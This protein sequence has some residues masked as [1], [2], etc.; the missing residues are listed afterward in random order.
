M[1]PKQVQWNDAVEAVLRSIDALPDSPES[2]RPV[3]GV[4]GP[5][6]SGKTTLANRLAETHDSSL[7]LSTD[8]YLPNYD[9]HPMPEW[10]LPER[11]DLAALAE[12]LCDLGAGRHA[13]VP[14]WSFHEH[15]RV[16]TE[17]VGPASLIICEGI[18]ALHEPLRKHLDVLV[19]VEA[20]ANVRWSR[21][22]RNE[23][24]GERGWGV[25]RARAFFDQVAEPIFASFAESFRSASHVIVLNSGEESPEAQR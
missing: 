2:R 16:G 18:H 12:H 7:V 5:V 13:E 6:G 9:E 23:I 22:E 15:R 1:D 17:R 10:D 24:K 21:W 8:R 4:T 19:F 11:S 14:I 20:P 25:D 3:V